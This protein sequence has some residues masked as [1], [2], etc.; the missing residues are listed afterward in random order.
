MFF[1]K[2]LVKPTCKDELDMLYLY[3]IQPPEEFLC[4]KMRGGKKF[5]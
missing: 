5:V 4:C 2:K 1:Y 3:E